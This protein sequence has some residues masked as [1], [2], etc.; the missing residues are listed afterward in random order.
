MTNAPPSSLV[1]SVCCVVVNWNGWQDTLRCLESLRAQDYP[2]LSVIA[3]DNGSTNDSEQRIRAAHPEVEL[4]QT[5]A[6]LGFPSGCNVGTRAAYASGADFI[7]L[8]NNDTVAPPDTAGKLVRT[9][10]ANP[11]AGAVGAV[12]YYLHDPSKVQ[13]WG[14]GSINLWTAYV[15]HYTAPANFDDG[16]SFLTGAS[17]L[18]PRRI[19]DQVGIFYEGFFMYCDDSDLCLRI[20]RAGHGLVVAQD[21]AVLHKEGGSSPPRSPL[22]DQFA[23]TSTLRLLRRQAPAPVLS[24]ALYLSLRLG[25]RLL[26]AEWPNLSAVLRGLRIFLAQRES[27]FTDRLAPDPVPSG[28]PNRAL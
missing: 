1:P 22:I 2:R 8:L 18:M 21:T 27:T 17:M 4:I 7:W 6:N 3:V 5:G 11:S 15:R 14:G 12:L 26:R 10:V 24:M 19:C 13:A 20:R 23:T 9:A 25:K 16:N 28:E